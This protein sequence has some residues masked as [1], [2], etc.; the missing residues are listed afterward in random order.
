MYQGGTGNHVSVLHKHHDALAL[1]YVSVAFGMQI[2]PI[3]VAPTHFVDN[4]QSVDT[5]ETTPT[6]FVNRNTQQSVMWVELKET[7]PTHL[8][9]PLTLLT[10]RIPSSQC[11]EWS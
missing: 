1:D 11:C 6:H 8:L 9:H 3:H 5:K 7:T 4:K 10:V 2:T